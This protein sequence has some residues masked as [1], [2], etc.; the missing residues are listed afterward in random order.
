MSSGE[1]E[2]LSRIL[3]AISSKG[4]G[5]AGQLL[6]AAVVFKLFGVAQVGTFGVLQGTASLILMSLSLAMPRLAAVR[7]GYYS[8]S[9]FLGATFCAIMTSCILYILVILLASDSGLY[10]A[11]IVFLLKSSDLV[12]ELNSVFYRKRKLDSRL[13]SSQAKRFSWVLFSSGLAFFASLALGEYLTVLLVGYLCSFV[14]DLRFLGFRTDALAISRSI[15][16]YKI[17]LTK[18]RSNAL[19][20]LLSSAT[21]T[22][23]R[24]AAL[25]WFGAEYAGAY[26]LVSYV[27]L[28]V[29]IFWSLVMQLMIV[30]V[31]DLLVM[32]REIERRILMFMVVF[33]GVAFFCLHAFGEYFFSFLTIDIVGLNASL[34]A[35]WLLAAS[36]PLVLRELY[37]YKAFKLGLFKGYNLV[38]LVGLAVFWGGWLCF[39]SRDQFVHI[40][41]I[42]LVANI[43][44][45]ISIYIYLLQV[46]RRLG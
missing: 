12:V 36:I 15:Y 34:L 24:Y 40:G 35:E 41:S 27:Y 31:K 16:A 43:C 37:S 20:A 26:Y 2:L 46:R 38:S 1:A 8:Y 4:F 10:V 6:I 28:A 23:P 33:Y 7:F 30:S 19:G 21:T 42:L 18:A 9:F 11:T 45:A 39:A 13:A 3:S 32:W 22:S 29:T 25:W 14:R 44:T 5:L 17:L